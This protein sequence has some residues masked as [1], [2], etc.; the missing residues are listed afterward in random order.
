MTANAPAN[1]LANETSPYLLQHAHNPVDWYPWGPAALER[2]RTEQKPIFL[3]IGYSACHWCHVMERECFENP[4]IA[5][6][7]NELYVNIKVD[8][9]E[10]PDVDEIYMKAVLA[11][12]GSGGWPMSMF[13]TPSL[14]PFFGATYLPP[15]RAYGRPSFPDVLTALAQAWQNDRARVAEQASLLTAAVS[16]EAS[17]DARGTLDASALTHSLDK[18][19]QSF[20]AQWGGFGGAPK[21]PHSGDLRLLLRHALRGGGAQA[22]AMAVHTLLRMADGGIYDQLGGGFHRY[23]VDRQWR[24]PHFEKMLY[25]NAQLV[26]AYLEA[27]VATGNPRFAQIAAECC[28]WA[29]REMQ[30]AEGGFASTQDADSE[31]EEGQFFAWTTAQVR[32][33]LG[34]ERGRAVA[35]WF[36]VTDQGNFEHGKSVLWMPVPRQTVAQH[37]GRPL[38]ELQALVQ[39]AKPELLAARTRRVHPATDDKVL[40]AWNGLMIGALAQAYQVLEDPLYLDA[41]QR[42]ARYVLDGM[43]QPDGRLF[44]TARHGRAHINA[45]LDDYAFVAQGLIDL[46][47]ASF[48]ER[49][50]REALALTQIVETRFADRE[51]GG[52]FTTGEGHEALITRCKSVQ[53]GALPAGSAV[54]ALSLLRLAELTARPALLAQ[55]HAAVDG[56]A[57]LALRH[58]QAFSHLLI[59]LDFRLGEPRQIVIAGDPA[60]TETKALLRSVRRTFRPQRVVTFATPGSDLTLLPVL[61]GKTAADQ[62]RAYVCQGHTCQAPT[63]GA[64]QLQAALRSL[65]AR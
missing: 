4:E 17:V 12:T 6:L 45:C 23:S 25:D 1:R 38:P 47:E 18:L 9:E 49:W 51:R 55:A 53:D 60:S 50:L 10:R 30:T 13:L 44:A 46:Y 61:E 41:A 52:Y 16:E 28:D 62:S 27:H 3:S 11:M 26:V 32:S 63:Q 43:R 59:A 15:V 21:F 7:M 36:D 8:R 48:D 19:R 20:D 2:A 64:D 39:S 14:Q 40:A 58:P 33:V 65:V 35:A 29:L 31:G 57:K 24:V 5:Q 56:L 37:V 34:D 54:H 22:Q 42:A